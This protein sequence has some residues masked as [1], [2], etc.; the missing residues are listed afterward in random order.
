MAEPFL[1]LE[2]RHRLCSVKEL[3]RNSRA[4]PVAGDVATGVLSWHPSFF[5]QGGN[6]HLV[7]V[8]FPHTG[9]TITKEE[10]HLFSGLWINLGRLRGADPLP[11]FNGL[12]NDTINGF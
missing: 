8:V 1:Q 2:E 4:R 7:N 11:G 10:M 3:G 12:A 9:P 5:T 6:Q